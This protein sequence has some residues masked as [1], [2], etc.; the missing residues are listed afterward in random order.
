MVDVVVLQP[1]HATVNY[2]RKVLP[3]TSP[4]TSVT[5]KCDVVYHSS[6]TTVIIDFITKNLSIEYLPWFQCDVWQDY[7]AFYS[8]KHLQQYDVVR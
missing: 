2:E 6:L 1:V 3:R 4:L 8:L 5:I 7:A